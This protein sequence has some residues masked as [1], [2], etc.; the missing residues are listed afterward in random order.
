MSSDTTLS[1]IIPVFNAERFLGAA[2]ESVLAAPVDG[3]E[4]IVVDDGST[5]G[6]ASIAWRCGAPV[7]CV[8]QANQGPSA[9]RNTG[10]SEAC[11]AFI[12]FLDADDLWVDG[13]LPRHFSMLEA[14]QE[15]DVLRGALQYLRRSEGSENG[16][17]PTGAAL[18]ALN[19]SGALFRRRAFEAVGRFDPD[20]RTCEDV[21]WYVRASRVGLRVKQAAEVFSL[22]RRHG[23]NTTCDVSKLRRDTF[24]VVAR[25]R[26]QT[27]AADAAK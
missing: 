8:Q 24:R 27:L 4:V 22:Y 11:G 21:D 2:I 19:I 1:M 18:P 5:D 10:L 3:L 9:A 25:H 23:A 6:S 20:M 12:G 13:A 26:A 15:V 16:W 17:Q 14:D 7:R